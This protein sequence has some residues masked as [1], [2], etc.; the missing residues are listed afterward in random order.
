VAGL[1]TEQSDKRSWRTLPGEIQL[2]RL[3]VPPGTYTVVVEYY[4][5][6]NGLIERKTFP[7][8]TLKAGEKRFLGYRVLG[9]S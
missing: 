5:H 8:L 6:T 9:P 7:A 4:D 1:V 2:A 3:A